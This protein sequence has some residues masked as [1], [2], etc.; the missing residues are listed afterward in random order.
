[1]PD[2]SRSRVHVLIAGVST[3][4]AAESAA[5]AGFD[6]TSLDAFAD[7]DQAT[8]VHAMSLPRDVG[9]SFGAWAAARAARDI[10]CDVVTYL[11]SFENHP[12]AVHLLA[13][14]R[15]LWGNSPAVLRRVRDPEALAAALETR[16]L[17]C[18]GNRIAD[19]DHTPDRW[20]LKPR[21]SGGG[22]GV[23][24]W[25]PGDPVPRTTYV[26]PFIDGVPGS[27]VFVAAGG[28][29]RPLG[30]TRQL[31]GDPTFGASGFRYCGS[32]LAAAG[33]PQFANDVRLLAEATRLVEVLA[34]AFDL[35]G[36]N[37]TDFV[38][39]DGTPVAVEVN[40]RYSASMELVERAYGISI[41]A[42]HAMACAMG[43]LLPFDLA[44][45]RMSAGAFG[46]AILFA[47]HDV[48]CGDTRSWLDDPHVRD[49]PHPGEHIA[50]GRPV[51]TIFAESTDSTRCYAELARR[52]ARMYDL[53]ESW[54][55]VA[56]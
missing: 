45:A 41:F 42:A 20:L 1:M 22:H 52:A 26:Q 33:D 27:I 37:G 53:L 5:L 47:R 7:L 2:A 50:A 24:W 39:R 6:V 4:A 35:V 34:D 25:Q 14:G 30:L 9:V 13:R 3:R 17:A 36:V 43:E 8:G 29:A 48:D 10:A 16:G 19:L 56:V 54:A 11:S 32:I 15:A 23:R 46:K 31:I 21:A 18:A 12:A 51:C 40:P 49:V 28:T 44:S 38:A 55:S